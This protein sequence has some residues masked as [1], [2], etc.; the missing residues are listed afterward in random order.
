[1]KTNN[2][3]I[4]EVIWRLWRRLPLCHTDINKKFNIKKIG[5]IKK[6]IGT[7]DI[8]GLMRNLKLN[9]SPTKTIKDYYK[10]EK[11]TKVK[12]IFGKLKFK[13]STKKLLDEVN[14]DF[15]PEVKQE[16]LKKLKR[17]EKQKGHSFKNIKDL[18]KQIEG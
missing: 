9:L 18:R 4:E 17:I 13:K 11:K 3:I 7:D 8:K 15:E 10:E 12:D 14:R 16:Y 5:V 1:M 2:K 6:D